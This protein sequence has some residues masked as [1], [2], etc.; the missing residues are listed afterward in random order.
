MIK[1]TECGMQS[2][3]SSRFTAK[4]VES[5]KELFFCDIGDLMAYLNRR[6]QPAV[7]AEVRDYPS[8]SWIDA[9]K[10][11]FVRAPE[12]FRSPMGWGIGAFRSRADAAGYGQILDLAGARRAVR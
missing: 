1:C 8:G 3:L 6:N 7:T 5:G 2:E 11:L 9:E 10:A 4:T 12:K